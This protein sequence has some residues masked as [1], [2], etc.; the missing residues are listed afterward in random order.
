MLKINSKL[1]CKP[2]SLALLSVLLLGACQTGRAPEANSAAQTEGQAPSFGS[3]IR[4]L[5]KHTDAVL[6]QRDQAAIVVVPEYQGRVMT[7]TA[8]G[9]TGSSSGWIN[10][11]LIAQGIL[12]K[13]APDALENHIYAF[14]GEERFWL[15]PEGGQYSIFFAPDT[16]FDFKHWS[17]PAAIDTTPWEVVKQSADSLTVQHA[18]TL[19]NY[20]ETNFK[21]SVT[22]R[23]DLLLPGQI[24]AALKINI[25]LQCQTVAYQTTNTI[26]NKGPKA[27][28]NP[29]FPALRSGHRFFQRPSPQKQTPS[30]YKEVKVLNQK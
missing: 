11:D 23:V 29:L 22:R 28:I 2:L 21:I 26:Q 16:P 18:F 4:F 8:S 9:L 25:P 27:W 12:A 3:D 24:E 7:T 15:G 17:T 1:G 19:S 30:N 13:P 6:L 20:S 14:G 10:Y 5:K